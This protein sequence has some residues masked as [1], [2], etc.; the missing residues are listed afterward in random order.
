MVAFGEA[1]AGAF[2]WNDARIFS[3]VAKSPQERTMKF[4]IETTI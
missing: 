3:T 4:K 1:L 2:S